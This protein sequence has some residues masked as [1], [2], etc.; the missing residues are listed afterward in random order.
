MCIHPAPRGWGGHRAPGGVAEL[1]ILRDGD[2]LAVHPKPIDAH[3]VGRLLALRELDL[4]SSPIELLPDTIQFLR[5]AAHQELAR[6]D[7]HHL[8]TVYGVGARAGI[9]DR[10]RFGGDRRRVGRGFTLTSGQADRQDETDPA[11]TTA[12]RHDDSKQIRNRRTY[13]VL[14][15]LKATKDSHSRSDPHREQGGWSPC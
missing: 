7:E 10:G 5:I 6:R 14:S 1:A 8:G 15:F 13:W 4:L 2:V 9:L 11:T 3:A 12:S